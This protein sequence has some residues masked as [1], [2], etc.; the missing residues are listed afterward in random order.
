MSPHGFCEKGGGRV[1]GTGTSHRCT[2]AHRTAGYTAA[3]LLACGHANSRVATCGSGVLG[4]AAVQRPQA[5]PGRA[6]AALHAR[7]E[8][9]NPLRNHGS[10]PRA[11]PAR[12]SYNRGMNTATE[13]ALLR[14][15][16]ARRLLLEPY[17]IDE[18]TLQRALASAFEHRLDDA[19]IYLQYTRSEGWSLEEGL[20]KSGS[21]GIEQGFGIRAIEGDKTAFAYSDDISAQRLLEAAS[22]VRAIARQGRGRVRL[23]AAPRVGGGHQLYDSLDPLQALDSAAKVAL[24]ARADEMARSADSRVVQVM[25]SLAGEYDV[26]LVMRAD[27]LLA[28]DVRPLVRLNVSVIA[29]HAGRRE[30]GSSGGGGRYALDRFDEA[31]L[32]HHVDEAVRQAVLNLESRPAPAGEMSVVLGSGW[33]GILLHE[34]IGHGLEGDFNRKGSSAFAG[35]IGQRVA[36]PGVT[37]LDDGTL[38]GRRGSLNI[39]DEGHPTERTV[40]IDNGV[41]VDYMQ[42][43]LNAR[44]MKRKPTGNARRESYA[45]APMPRMT[46]TYML[47]GDRDP[48]EIVASLDRGLYAVNFGGGQVDITSGKFVFSAS[49]AWWVENG[50]LQYPVKGATL[51]GNGPDVL[52]RVSMIGNDMQ[53][54]PGVGTCGKEGQSVPVGV[55]QPTLRIDRVTVGGTGG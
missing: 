35:R 46:N 53:L 20:V 50:R 27:G 11:T 19:D 9:A 26:V 28:A 4:R 43:S 48:Q 25:A 52:T 44:L 10:P 40:L 1:Q 38:A 18:S 29:E 8:S 17:G 2:D 7:A 54:D 3:A 12:G 32:R 13:P 16:E 45:H 47:G 41:L 37:V 22:T 39:D 34:A 42:D 31:T 5:S 6:A 21:F 55:G 30:T 15:H 23:G 49:E 51:I 33:P 14:L 24:L 36:A